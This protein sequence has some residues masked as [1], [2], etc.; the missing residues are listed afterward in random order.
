MLVT[1]MFNGV[2]H[3]G[4]GNTASVGINGVFIKDPFAGGTRLIS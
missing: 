1:L 2:S 4:G 3:G